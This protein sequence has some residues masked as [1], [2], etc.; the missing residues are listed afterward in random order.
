VGS[1]PTFATRT[2]SD[3][4]ALSDQ[5]DAVTTITPVDLA[6]L[7]AWADRLTTMPSAGSWDGGN[8]RADGSYTMPYFE[9]DPEMLRFLGDAGAAGFV[10]PVDWRAWSETP[11]W[12]DLAGDPGLVAGADV[13]EL[14]FLL[15]TIVRGNRFFDGMIADAFD[16]GLLLAICRRAAELAGVKEAS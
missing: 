5:R 2:G 6:R 8:Q 11:R 4:A 15:T 10:Q 14:V 13:E 1:N 16:H 12:A 7:A 3:S 9:L